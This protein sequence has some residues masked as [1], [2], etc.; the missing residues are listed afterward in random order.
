MD[1]REHPEAGNQISVFDATYD[2]ARRDPPCAEKIG[3]LFAGFD[4]RFAAFRDTY[5][6]Y[7]I[8]SQAF[9]GANAVYATNGAVSAISDA[10]TDRV[11]FAV[12][13]ANLD[14]GI[15]ALNLDIAADTEFAQVPGAALDNG[16]LENPCRN[17]Q[18]I[19]ETLY[20]CKG[21]R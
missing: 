13:V 5:L 2:P 12:R 17:V 14:A 21:G 20:P 19:D 8:V 3:N 15:A 1:T 10:S 4:I 18:D 6:V 11:I 16:Y 9:A 7:R